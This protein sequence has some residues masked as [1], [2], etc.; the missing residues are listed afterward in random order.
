VSIELLIE[1][2]PLVAAFDIFMDIAPHLLV[3][4]GGETPRPLYQMLAYSGHGWS[5]TDVFFSDERC[6]PTDHPDSNYRMA[7]ETLLGKVNALA[8]PMPG[9]SC[10]ADAYEQDLRAF[11]ADGPVHFDLAIL[12]LGEDGHTASLFPGD[13]ALE[14]RDRL[15]VRVERPDHPRLTLT[16]PALSAAETVLFLVTGA[17]KAEALRA[18]VASDDIPASR[19]AARR[20][21]VVCDHA[22][23]SLKDQRMSSG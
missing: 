12:G 5:G 18:L 11:F 20:R 19:V 23:A 15:V 8:H 9:G 16:L 21:I 4:A 13:P 1:D 6:V 7:Y 22:A 3:L 2:D 14:E 17:S 10:N